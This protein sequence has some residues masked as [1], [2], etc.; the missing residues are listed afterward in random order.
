MSVSFSKHTILRTT[1]LKQNI[2]EESTESYSPNEKS[3]ELIQ[4]Q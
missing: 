1:M 2:S 4:E 3:N